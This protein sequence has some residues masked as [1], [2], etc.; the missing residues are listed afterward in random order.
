MALG[1]IDL[2][3][4]FLQWM[5]RINDL[6]TVS[7]QLTEGQINSSGVMTLTGTGTV[8]NL[9][10]GL[11]KANGSLLTD[12]K[13]SALDSNNI[14]FTSNS[15]SIR[16]SNTN[17]GR[18]GSTYFIE[19]ANLSV[20]LADTSNAN[21]ATANIMNLVHN[22]ALGAN[23]NALMAHA[24][25][26]DAFGQANNAGLYVIP[27]FNQANTAL[28]VG[29]GAFAKANTPDFP[30][31]TKL[32]FQQTAA[33]TGWTKDTTHNNK[34]L[35]IVSGTVGSGGTVDFTTAFTSKTPT[36]TVG[37]TSLTIAQMPSHNHTASVSDPGHAHGVADPT[38]AHGSNLA[39]VGQ[40][41][42]G[43]R[44][45]TSSG[46]YDGQPALLGY[47]SYFNT[48]A[49]PTYIGIYGAG[50]GISVSTASQG[51]GASHNHS[52]TMDAIDFA[53]KYVDAIVA[54]KD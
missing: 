6:V 5:V 33:P 16:V 21:I 46:G 11:I 14:I 7:N 18:L 51:S 38:H 3:Q 22:K 17:S 25:A 37:G 43:G 15:S 13:T 24:L 39:S 44:G 31:G 42:D 23:I 19:F 54:T 20:S 9:V 29:Q 45:L 53:V 50:T 30:S 47:G 4:S 26:V 10:S 27:A 2:N 35:R 1:N 34:A 52:L 40:I 32:L 49:G 48:A 41:G 8:L 36:G 28:S 12:L